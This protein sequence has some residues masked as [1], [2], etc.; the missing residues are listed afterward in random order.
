[1]LLSFAYLAFSAMLQ[2]LVGRRRSTFAKNVELLVL[3]HQLAVVRRQRPRPTVRPADCA[4]LAA[5][6]RILPSPRRRGLIV[7]PQTLV[8]WHRELVRR[9]WA[10][11]R[12]E[13]ACPSRPAGCSQEEVLGA[14]PH[15]SERVAA[16]RT[17]RHGVPPRAI[18][19]LPVDARLN[20]AVRFAGRDWP[21]PA[22]AAGRD[23]DYVSAR[24][25]SAL[26]QPRTA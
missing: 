26:R 3:R 15:S 18:E 22:Q 17:C 25:A 6:T 7:T 23:P 19:V 5:L 1:M 9:R 24:R 4:F 8:R 10:Q 11:G 2:L 16:C 13:L 20:S 14:V 21:E 12:G